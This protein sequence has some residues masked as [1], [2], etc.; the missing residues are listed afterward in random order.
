MREARVVEANSSRSSSDKAL[1]SDVTEAEAAKATAARPRDDGASLSEES[2]G[3]SSEEE[4]RA[5]AEREDD[6]GRDE[7][8]GQVARIP[9]ASAIEPRLPEPMPRRAD[10]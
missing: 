5:E 2:E 7:V 1:P 8:E 4:G 6:G 10:E 3:A 9:R